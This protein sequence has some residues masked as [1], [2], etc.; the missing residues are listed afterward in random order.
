MSG[1]RRTGSPPA[2]NGRTTTA[3]PDA[4]N[5]GLGASRGSIRGIEIV[6]PTGDEP[7]NYTAQATDQ[8]ELQ[9]G[10]KRSINGKIGTRKIA[11]TIVVGFDNPNNSNSNA[12]GSPKKYVISKGRFPVFNE[13]YM[14][15]QTKHGYYYISP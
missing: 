6:P 14:I 4:M 1:I 15:W 3:A 7:K 2:G 13:I 9:R 5:E 10:D 11:K 12:Y 8:Y